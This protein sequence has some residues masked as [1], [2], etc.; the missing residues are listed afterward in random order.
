MHMCVYIYIYIYMYTRFADKRRNSQ[1]DSEATRCMRPVSP[2]IYYYYYYYH[3]YYY[4]YYFLVICIA[5]CSLCLYQESRLYNPAFLKRLRRRRRWHSQYIYI[6]IYIYI[7]IYRNTAC[8]C[9]YHLNLGLS[10]YT[11]VPVSVQSRLPLELGACKRDYLL[12]PWGS[13]MALVSA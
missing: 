5:T 8:T 11:T 3:Y 12:Y 13:P 6:Y 4:Y 2:L 10:V 7:C 1:E 9:I